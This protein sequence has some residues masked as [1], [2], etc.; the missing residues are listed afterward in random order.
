[1]GWLEARHPHTK[2]NTPPTQGML[3][4]D[5]WGQA[6]YQAHTKLSSLPCPQALA[7]EG[8]GRNPVGVLL[9]Q[10]DEY[11]VGVNSV[12]GVGQRKGGTW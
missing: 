9:G 3:F 1:M 4:E 11:R 7:S 10:K 5:C 6:L 8:K 12:S 2:M